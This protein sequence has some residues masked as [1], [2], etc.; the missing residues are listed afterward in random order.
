MSD[1]GADAADVAGGTLDVD[2][3][4]PTSDARTTAANS[5][6]QAYRMR[7]TRGLVPKYTVFR[8]QNKPSGQQ[9]YPNRDAVAGRIFADA[10]QFS[11]GRTSG[12]RDFNV[13]SAENRRVVLIGDLSACLG[14]LRVLCVKSGR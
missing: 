1:D 3:L 14:G 4:Q 2:F 5:Q 7:I 8:K 11:V 9:P 12:K 10:A 13:E 6:A